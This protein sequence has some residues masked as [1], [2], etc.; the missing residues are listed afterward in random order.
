MLESVEKAREEAAKAMKQCCGKSG[1]LLGLLLM[2]KRRR[3][4]DAG[5]LVFIGM[6]DVAEYY[7]CAGQSL[8]KNMVMEPYFFGA[9]LVDRLSYSKLLGKVDKPPRTPDE[10]L[11]VGDD[12]TM[13]DVERL[14]KKRP[15]KEPVAGGLPEDIESLLKEPAD[16]KQLAAAKGIVAEAVVAEKYPTIRWNFPWRSRVVVGVP[17]GITDR[18]VYEFKATKNKFLALFRKPVALVQ[19]D[20]YG[21]FFRRPEKRVQIHIFES[22]ETLTWHEPVDVKAAEAVLQKFET[23]DETRMFSAPKPWKCQNCWF[24][25]RFC[26][27]EGGTVVLSLPELL[28]LQLEYAGMTFGAER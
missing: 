24:K 16:S 11:K 19:A 17:D 9:Y 23:V 12:L 13:D 7:W 22:G 5:K 1:G 18:F 2:E 15:P 25:G 27:L 3:G 4:A 6:A 20:L 26:N 28:I 10:L 8:I 21:M 14:L